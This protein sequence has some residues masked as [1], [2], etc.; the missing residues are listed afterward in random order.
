MI[1]TRFP[2]ALQI[3][4]SLALAEAEGVP[5]LSSAELAA[6][7]G[8]HGT[9]VRKLL[10]PLIRDG[11]LISKKGKSGGMSLGRAADRI[12]LRDIL[13][14]VTEEKPLW[15]SRTDFPRRCIVTKGIGD[16][17][18]RLATNAEEAARA[19]L[20]TCTL[21]QALDDLRAIVERDR[22]NGDATPGDPES[23]SATSHCAD[24]R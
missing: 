21:A 1:D 14:S 3:M 12:T 20:Q 24:L 9:F 8:G 4:L 11:L 6:S 13:V 17:F 7:V 22:S 5:S 23:S 18:D 19:T 16:Y 15:S 10:A 2:T